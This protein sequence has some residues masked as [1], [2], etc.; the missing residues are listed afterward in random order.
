MPAHNLIYVGRLI[1]R[2]KN[3]TTL[4]DAFKAVKEQLPGAADWGLLLVGDGEDREQL[5]T[6]IQDM[7]QVRIITGRSWQ[8]VPAYLALSNALVLPSYSEPWGLVVNEAMVCELPVLVSDRCGCAPDLVDP[9]I[10]GFVF[11]PYQ[12][13]QLLDSLTKLINYSAAD[14]AGMGMASAKKIAAYSPEAVAGEML[15]GFLTVGR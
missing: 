7:P 6:L 1:D 10:N 4:I 11:D 2:L 9:G 12:P 3:I 5:T 15:N 14:R 13:E 8:D